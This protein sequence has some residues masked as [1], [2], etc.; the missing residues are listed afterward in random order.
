MENKNPQEPVTPPLPENSEQPTAES[1]D[2][3]ATTQS[4]S[5]HPTGTP[6]KTGG[7]WN[8]AD[9]IPP[10]HPLP[11]IPP[12]TARASV[13]PPSGTPPFTTS[14]E[15]PSA[16]SD[17]EDTNGWYFQPD[18][19]RS[20]PAAPAQPV[21]PPPPRQI[22][23]QPPSPTMV[24]PSHAQ[25]RVTPPRPS[26]ETRPSAFSNNRQG[27]PTPLPRRVSEVDVNATRVSPVQRSNTA[28]A[29]RVGPPTSS[30]NPVLRHTPPPVSPPSKPTPPPPPSRP[31]GARRAAGC[32]L[33]LFI[34]LSF[35]IVILLL[36]G[37]SYAIYYYYSI[38]RNLPNVSQ[39]KSRVSQF[40]TTRILDRNGNT[41]YE[42]LDPNAGRRSYTPLSKISPYLIA[43]T[44]ATEDKD[45]YSHQGFDPVAIVRALWQNYITS[46]NGPGAS[47]I[48]QQLARALLL[49][50]EERYERT[51]ERKA[52][53]IVLAAELTRQYTKEE[54][55]E[56]Y[57]NEIYYGNLA[58][59][60]EAAAETYFNTTASNL[61]LNQAAF[62][63]GLPQAPSV[64]DIYTN[65]SE[66]LRRHKT[67]LMLMY[68]L[69][70]EKNCIYISNGATVAPVCVDAATTAQAASEMESYEF[71]PNQ[72]SI[73]YP[74]WVNYVRSLLEAQFDPQ[75]IYRSGFTVYTTLDPGLQDEA[76]RIV[77]EHV[78]SLAGQN[79][80][81]GALVAI[82]PNTGEILAMV[83]SAD[84]YNDAISGQVNMAVSNTRQ[85]GSSIKPLTYAAAFEK[86]WNPATILWDVP[87]DFPPSGD[88]NDPR[89]PYQP[90][91][92]DGR[93]H[94]PVSIRTA[95]AN[96]YNIPAVKALQF[97]GIFDNTNTPA[98]DG[99]ISFA[100]RLGITSL[101]RPDYGLALTLGGGEVSLLEMTGAYAV[102]ANSG[103]RVAPVAITKIT[104][105]TGSVVYQYEVPPGDQVMRVEHAYLISSILSDYNARIPAFGTDPVINLPFPA[106]AKTGTTNDFRDNWTVGYTPDVAIGVWVGNADYTPMQNTTG[107]TGAAPIWA[108]TMQFAIQQLTGSN[109]TPFS[110]PPGVVDRVVCSISGAQPSQWCSDQRTEIFASDQ[111]PPA[112]SN[113]LWQKTLID[114]WTGLRA[115]A[116]CADFSE[117]KFAININDYW[118]IKWIKENGEG[119]A[120]AQQMGFTPPI[121][122]AP[123]RE[124]KADDPRPIIQFTNLSEGQT[125]SVNPLELFGVIDASAD[126]DYYRID[127]GIGEMPIEWR[128]LIDHA[129]APIRQTDKITTWDLK[130]LPPGVIT[131][132]IYLHSTRD[133]YA[134]K[135][136]HINI[137]VPTPTPTPSPTPT[138][139]P[140]VTPTPTHTL[141]PTLTPTPEPT[142]TLLP[143]P[144]PSES[145]PTPNP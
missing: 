67:V 77:T 123:Q 33:R 2:E 105:H 143:P 16:R 79:V 56:I 60:I 100:R 127:Y 95:L 41:L 110:R 9:T 135:K 104:D 24:S 111:L 136:I 26:P 30:P 38:A 42:I 63:A 83:G 99:L 138:T 80:T 62:L 82:R 116:A 98:P 14:V 45:Y 93:Y 124:C 91:N 113:D 29:R 25:T 101:T 10:A 43:A 122:F 73:R 20:Q 50:P 72:T 115:S 108:Q 134:E 141:T 103:R 37:G 112:A 55:L 97:V 54:I 44:I 48:T 120:W 121:F 92:Y 71:K 118:G 128:T 47:T 90:V 119:Q 81:D 75:T 125:I 64:Y 69:S 78:Q 70:Q 57:L 17:S 85:P 5:R 96:S 21:S 46:G 129:S 22:P 94:G 126:F 68:N 132:R 117:E 49:S 23:T 40:E 87:T 114:T 61:T 76:Q 130:D 32:L 11:T 142:A 137:Q 39:L 31:S 34:I 102:F 35:I 145:T 139:T 27:P 107:L 88:P 28:G 51:F 36:A 58:Y 74:H 8:S 12:T 140:T 109:P 4:I 19:T 7:W 144:I 59:G 3:A 13:P 65:R 86:G 15:E 106:A 66:T 131:L 1:K 89:E 133:T 53:E 18:E 84:F 6:D 52:R